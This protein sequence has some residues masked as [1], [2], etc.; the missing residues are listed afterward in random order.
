LVVVAG[1][2]Q[3]SAGYDLTMEEVRLNG[4]V[5]PPFWEKKED[6]NDY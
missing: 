3:A 1:G 2:E 4:E 5:S 6:D